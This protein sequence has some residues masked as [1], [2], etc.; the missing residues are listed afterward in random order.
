MSPTAVQSNAKL[1]EKAVQAVASGEVAPLSKK[2]RKRPQKGPELTHIKVHPLVW[3]TAK[4]LLASQ[5][6]FTK[7]EVK[8]EITVVVR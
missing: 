8:D 6:G 2:P 4:E 3:S 7:I 1:H 5:R